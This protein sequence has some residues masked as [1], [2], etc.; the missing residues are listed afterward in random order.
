M[1]WFVWFSK[2]WCLFVCLLDLFLGFGLVCFLIPK[3]F[4]VFLGFFEGCLVFYW[5]G[6]VW[7]S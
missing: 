1:G 2:V 5:F 6:L 3:V 7:C 4:V